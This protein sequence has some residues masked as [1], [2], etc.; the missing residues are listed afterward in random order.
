[1]ADLSVEGIEWV[2]G[3][4]DL[5]WSAKVKLEPNTESTKG[6][7]PSKSHI[8]TSH[9]QQS[10]TARSLTNTR[11]TSQVSQDLGVAVDQAAVVSSCVPE[12]L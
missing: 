7:L 6:Q 11:S 9:T 8:Q 1:M 5:G 2:L 3:G 4:C 12:W 10:A